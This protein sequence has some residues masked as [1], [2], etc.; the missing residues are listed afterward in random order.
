M[1]GCRNNVFRRLGYGFG[2]ATLEL[3]G[4]LMRLID[5]VADLVRIATA[6]RI[7]PIGYRFGINLAKAIVKTVVDPHPF[8]LVGAED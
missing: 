8:D 4:W 2:T 6:G 1:L 3:K 5:L 7:S